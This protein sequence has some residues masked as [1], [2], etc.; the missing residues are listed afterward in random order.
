MR[1]T[2]SLRALAVLSLLSAST[3]A[4]ADVED[5]VAVVSPTAAVVSSCAGKLQGRVYSL[6][7]ETRR[8]PDFEALRPVSALCT[9]HLAVS[10]RRGFPGFPGVRDRV[11]W[12]GVDFRGAF[13]VAQPATYHFR[14]TSDDGA[15]LFIDG[16]LVVDN[17]GYHPVS[18]REGAVT[19]APGPHTI[20]VPFWQGPGPMA[21][22]LEVAAPGE[23]YHVFRVDR[24]LGAG[25]R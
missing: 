14:I 9:D 21:L 17:D 2:T 10:E 23:G 6:P 25:A 22:I 19:L 13:V 7:L 24:P 3:A 20:A 18:S 16:A 8:L 5:G 4:C 12:F 1:L 15:R 11:E